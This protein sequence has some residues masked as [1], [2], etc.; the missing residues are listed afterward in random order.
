MGKWEVIKSK[1][2][3]PDGRRASAGKRTEQMRR[4]RLQRARWRERVANSIPVPL[5][6]AGTLDSL[7]T[8]CALTIK[9][10]IRLN[11]FDRVS[12]P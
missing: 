8:F 7:R 12:L 11:V 2:G 9:I 6:P 4:A 5:G 3:D 1:T 10:P